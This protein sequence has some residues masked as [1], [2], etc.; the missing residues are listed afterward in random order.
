MKKI[1]KGLGRKGTKNFMLTNLRKKIRQKRI[2]TEESGYKG[3]R[4]LTLIDH[5]E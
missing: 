4:E 2:K 5:L 3:V 1:G